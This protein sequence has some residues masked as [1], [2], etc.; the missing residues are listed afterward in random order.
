[1]EEMRANDPSRRTWV[2][3]EEGS[4]FPIQNIPFGIAGL[5]TKESV[6]VTRI[7]DWGDAP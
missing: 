7:G 1:M 3:V 4:D 5:E 2:N 6:I